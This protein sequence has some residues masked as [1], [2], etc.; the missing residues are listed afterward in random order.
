MFGGG[1]DVSLFSLGSG[2]IHAGDTHIYMG[3]SGWVSSVVKKRTVDIRHCIASILGAR[4]GYYNYVSELETSGKCLEWVKDHLALDE[5]GVYLEKKQ[6]DE[7]LDARYRSM[8]DYLNE[9]I[10]ETEPGSGGVVFTPW[11]QGNRSPFED[12]KVRAMFFNIGLD[13][14]KRKLIRAVVEGLAFHKR[15]M[16]ECI[17]RKVKINEPLRFVGGGALSNA[18]CQIL[19]DSTG[20]PIE[21]VDNPQNAG[22]FGAAVL[23][24][25]GLGRLSSFEAIRDAIPIRKTFHSDPSLRAL[26]DR[27][28]R[29]FRM[30][31]RQ[32]RKAFHLLNDKSPGA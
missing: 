10:G 23:C 8:L 29:A 16:L 3:T 20:K 24:G 11:L 28:Y 7:G 25:V 18:T 30:L 13:T 31:Y 17:E 27:Q 32:N 6:V 12:S 9:I 14:G 2:S 1:G 22:A 15:W 4:P 19:E 26:Y 21:A 5:I